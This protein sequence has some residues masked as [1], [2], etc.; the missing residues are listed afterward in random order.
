M[1]ASAL[2]AKVNFE[3]RNNTTVAL[4]YLYISESH[5]T[6]WGNDVL[7]PE[8]IIQPGGAVGIDF[9]DL[10]PQ[11]CFYDILAIF[12]DED[13]VESMQVNVCDNDWYEFYE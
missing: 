6:D 10:S 2:A 7:G 5:L 8:Q 3:V 1:A 9:A 4:E 12:A 13:E 11:I